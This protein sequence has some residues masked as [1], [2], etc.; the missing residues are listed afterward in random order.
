[1]IECRRA[2]AD[3]PPG[4]DGAIARAFREEGP[5]ILATLDPAGRRLQLAEDALQDAFAGRGRDLAARRR[6]RPARRVDHHHRAAQGASTACAASVGWPTASRAWRA[7]RARRPTPTRRHEDDDAA[8][9]D[10]RL[11]LIFTCC[12]PALALEARVALTA[13]STLGGLTTAEVAPRVPGPR[14]DDGPAP[15]ARQ[16]QD[17]RGATSPTASRPPHLLPERLSGVLA[18]VY[19]IFNEGYAAAEGDRLV[20]GELCAEAIRL[21]RLLVRLVPDDAEALGPAGPACCCRTPAAAP[22]STPAGAYVAL[23]PPGPLALGPGPRRRG[24]PRAG[25]GPGRVRAPGPYQLQAAIAALHATAPT[26][27]GHRL[28]ADRRPLRR[29]RPPRALAR[30]AH[31]PRRRARLRGQPGGG[32]RTARAAAWPTR[33]WTATPRCTRRTPS[34]CAASTPR[35][36][37]SAAYDRA[38]ARHGQRRR[39]G[40]ARAPPRGRMTPRISVQ[41]VRKFD[42]TWYLARPAAPDRRSNAP[43]GAHH[44][45]PQGDPRQPRGLRERPRPRHPDPRAG[46]RRLRQR[47]REVPRGRHARERVHRLPPEA[48]RLRPAPGRRPDD[49]REAAVRRHHA[50]ADGH[51]RRRRRA[52]RAAQQ[53]PHH[54]APEHPDPPH[55]AARRRRG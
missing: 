34:C 49:P 41:I 50:G 21:G 47:G 14:A 22:A 11:R 6:A 29:A 38:I 40:R 48:G 12:H 31:Q 53:G 20:R 37:P 33:G 5:A 36:P 42:G 52:V 26:A 45:R 2:R 4:E 39:A 30:G 51:V 19:L 1:M 8:V 55:P 28:G 32:P 46:V 7:R 18:V 9:A 3:G 10:D 15:G 54:D 25:R 43:H 23:R 44:R 13:A 16:A 24:H 35:P 17:R 27:D